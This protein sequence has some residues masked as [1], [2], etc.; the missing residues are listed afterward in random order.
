[1]PTETW[2]N[3]LVEAFAR[4]DGDDNGKIDR[5]EFGSLLDA[6]GSTMSARDRDIGFTLIDEDGDDVIS[7][8]ELSSWWEVVRAEGGGDKS[9]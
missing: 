1:M 3:D 9:V 6:L 5:A 4:F 7:L 2:R 8:A